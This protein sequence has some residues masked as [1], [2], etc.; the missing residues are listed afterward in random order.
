MSDAAKTICRSS[1]SQEALVV[2]LVVDL[3]APSLNTASPMHSKLCHRT[4]L[5][6]RTHVVN[7]VVIWLHV[8]I[9]VKSFFL[10]A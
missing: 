1:G 2:D 10:T 4:P 9:H 8:A 5:A 3:V 7:F 6:G